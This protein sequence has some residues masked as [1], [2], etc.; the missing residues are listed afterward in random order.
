M[1]EKTI[2]FLI[3]LIICG[4]SLFLIIDNR[5]FIM[6]KLKKSSITILDDVGNVIY[7]TNN[8]LKF[9]EDNI[10]KDN[11]IADSII[12]DFIEDIKNEFNY[13]YKE[14][15]A[16]L[17]S[18]NLI[19]NSTIDS[20]I[21][22]KIDEVFNNKESF[23]GSNSRLFNQSAIVI[24]D[25]DGNVKGV[26]GGNNFDTS[27]NRASRKLLKVGS[28]IKPVS[29]YSLGIEK[30]IINFSTIIE[31]IP[32]N[33]IYNGETIVW[34]RNYNDIY[35]SNVT[36]TDALKKSKNTVA[37]TVGSMIGEDEIFNFLKNS[38]GYAT[39]YESDTEDD[40]KQLSALALGYFKEGITL[41][42]LVSSYTMFGD[43]GYYKGKKY[44]ISV[45]DENG[46]II[47]ENKNIEKKVISYETASIMNRLL[48][49]NIVDEDSIIKNMKNENYEV[50][51][52]TG[53]VA[54]D[55]NNII[56]NLF[57]GMTP[58]YVAGVWIGYDDSRPMLYGTYKSATSI[59]KSIFDKINEEKSKFT[60]SEEI[61]ELEYCTKSGMLKS[62]TCE[63]SKIGY[64][65][66]NNIPDL[67]NIKH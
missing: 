45:I 11:D 66:K 42:T 20:E 47:I 52:K 25:Y 22:S 38:L 34:P 67:C 18:N 4:V 3:I 62:D 16:F 24:M 31:D 33:T 14:A 41:D 57:V 6:S 10:I 40:D 58:E 21:Q 61:F 5:I 36:V 9:Y 53:T 43:G 27:I 17:N 65:K 55:R 56:S 49:N 29:I 63:E 2:K 30:D 64:Y 28:T 44:Y 51:G 39:L 13:S 8:K 59:W 37:V 7:R 32:R 19:I 60:L 23:T 46:D 50:L 15:I 35:E 54:D 12:N 1:K 26:R 48:L